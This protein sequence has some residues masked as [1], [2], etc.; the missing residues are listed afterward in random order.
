MKHILLNNDNNILQFY[1][2][3]DVMDSL[4]YLK[5]RLPS[6]QDIKD[7][8]KKG[9]D[10]N[11]T[12]IVNEYKNEPS[13]LVEKI[14]DEISKIDNKIPLYDIYTKNIYLINK[15]NVYH[16]VI[17]EN[18]RFPDNNMV[19]ILREKKKE[20]E[21]QIKKNKIKTPANIDKIN[22][23]KKKLE[24]SEYDLNVKYRE[25]YLLR[26][27]DKLDL[28]IQF[29]GYFNL[30]I[31]ETT[32]I[33]IFYLYANQVGKNITICKRPSFKS[34]FKHI[35]PYYTRSELINLG[36]N[37][38]LIKESDKYYDREEV[39]KLCQKV[40]VNDISATTII[41]HQKYII[42]NDNIG[43]IQY[44]SFQGSYFINQYLRFPNRFTIQN[45][46]L[47]TSIESV[48]NLVNNAPIFDKS[49]TVYR[50]I[51]NDNYLQSLKVGDIYVE[52][53]FISTTRNP[54]YSSEIYKFGYILIKIKIPRNTPGVGLCIESFSN[55]P[56]EEEIIFAP[57]SILKLEKKNK[58]S[59]YYHTDPNFSKQVVTKYEFSYIGREK[60]QIDKRKEL[61]DDNII[62]FLKLKNIDSI[63]IYERI[64]YFTKNHLNKIN[65]FKTKI[66]K[67]IYDLIVESYDSTNSY[68]KF[69]G[70]T[71]NNGFS[72]YTIMDNYILFFIEIGEDNGETFMYVNY[73]FRYAS[74]NK[75]RKLDD[76]DFIDFVAELAYYFKIKTTILYAEYV[77]SDVGYK[78]SKNTLYY[79]GNYCLDFYEYLKFDK[80]RFQNK[81]IDLDTIIVK[82]QFSYYELDRL[83]EII[84]DVILTTTNKDEIYQIYHKTYKLSFPK[85]KH[86]L[87]D[88]YIWIVENQCVYLDELIKKISKIYREDN[89]FVSD[90]Y[91]F[92]GGA[93]LYNNNK[94]NFLPDFSQ[95]DS[96]K[97]SKLNKLPKNEY[98]LD[99]ESRIKSRR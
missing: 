22:K 20:I 40:I 75:N 5:A 46:L 59:I 25:T 27:Y 67:N 32:Y 43:L 35:K 72:I 50:F 13:K 55:F 70:N 49:Y 93:Y 64:K 92:N 87:S 37:M 85:E 38:G 54:F 3:N 83:K 8:P 81:N 51:S 94:I 97:K 99:R 77:S 31:L 89:P 45:K 95:E 78:E 79:G 2:E 12:G 29:I 48:W 47:E 39:M 63:T 56:E 90:F 42:D 76:K 24:E 23:Q 1:H 6:E 44:Y 17:Y 98:R 36:L 73:Y 53:S 21:P 62:Q 4:Y 41:E 60:I 18:Y 80:K 33:T 14:R 88:F 7:Y 34:H 74:N 16:R 9:T 28:M 65:Q 86:N 19:K 26:K 82:P 15:E 57:K 30:S 66:G 61:K 71:T 58:D 10:K 91:I 68:K 11:I 96:D 69:Y 84:P 52:P